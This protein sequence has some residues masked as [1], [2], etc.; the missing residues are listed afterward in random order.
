MKSLN[1]SKICN[2]YKYIWF[3]L[4][5]LE[6]NRFIG[7]YFLRPTVYVMGAGAVLLVLYDL[8]HNKTCLRSRDNIWLFLFIVFYVCTCFLRIDYAFMKNIIVIMWL[9]ISF[10]FLAS[11]DREE[12]LESV[13]RNIQVFVH[14]MVI[15]SMIAAILSVACVFLRFGGGYAYRADM[16]DRITCFGVYE[17][18]LWGV[19][20][21]PN[22]GSLFSIIGALCTFLSMGYMPFKR[23]PKWVL[24]VNLVFQYLYQVFADSRTA[25]ISF[26]ILFVLLLF[27]WWYHKDTQH[28]GFAVFK[29]AV[30][31]LAIILALALLMSPVKQ[32]L[33]FLANQS[34]FS[35]TPVV[36]EALGMEFSNTMNL[37]SELS[38]DREDISESNWSNGRF[39]IWSDALNIWKD[40]PV[41][42]ASYRGYLDYSKEVYPDS[43]MSEK[44]K[45]FH[46]DYVAYLTSSGLVGFAVL[47]VFVILLIIR[48][49]RYLI[50]YKDS[51]EESRMVWVL[52]AVLLSLFAAGFFLQI[53]SY[54]RTWGAATF[55]FCLGWLRYLTDPRDKDTILYRLG[56]KFLPN[57]THKERP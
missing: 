18:R 50:K 40:M 56:T 4:T 51:T 19:F 13:K 45:P 54:Q 24:I 36:E 32:G 14:I 53:F 3:V 16:P 47:T 21:D 49:I 41:F 55:F 57:L 48:T 52:F 1:Y 22:F 43:Y 10:F 11:Y 26:V 28:T 7:H 35:L 9:G 2:I 38:M 29:Q 20:W 33:T 37:D 25:Q 39:K 8:L 27:G 17:N 12:K 5:I 6:L 23:M 46:N 44:E 34:S 42:G 31:S 15:A 30:G